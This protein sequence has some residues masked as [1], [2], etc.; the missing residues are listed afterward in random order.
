[1]NVVERSI[2][3]EGSAV[4]HQVIAN[5]S[6]LSAIKVLMPVWGSRYIRQFLEFC[7]PTMLAPGNIPALAQAASVHLCC[8]DQPEGRSL[9][10]VTI[11]PGIGSP[12]FATSKFSL[13]MI[14]LPTAITA[15]Q[16]HL[17]SHVQSGNQARRC[18]TPVSYF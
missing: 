10:S 14:S 17:P 13:S 8:Y 7:L 16:L 12:R 5:R 15:R 9:S 3:P 6:P 2:T 4:N 11:P 18:L 1:M